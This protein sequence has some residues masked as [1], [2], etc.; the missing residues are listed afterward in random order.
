MALTTQKSSRLLPFMTPSTCRAFLLAT[1]QSRGTFDF[2]IK[3]INSISVDLQQAL[4][5]LHG[6]QLTHGSVTA[7]FVLIEKVG[8]N[9]LDAISWHFS[10]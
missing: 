1:Y 5:Y 2:T 9:V 7:D 8:C 3:D 4:A 6:N 10:S